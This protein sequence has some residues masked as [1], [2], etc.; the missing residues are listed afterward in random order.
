MTMHHRILW[1][2]FNPHPFAHPRGPAP[3]PFIDQTR[4]MTVLSRPYSKSGVVDTDVFASFTEHTHNSRL[5]LLNGVKV[6]G[7]WYIDSMNALRSGYGPSVMMDDIGRPYGLLLSASNTECV[8]VILSR[9]AFKWI[10][11]LA[12]RRKKPPWAVTASSGAVDA[13]LPHSTVST[14]LS[15]FLVLTICPFTFKLPTFDNL[16]P[17]DMSELAETHGSD[18]VEWAQLMLDYGAQ[19]ENAIALYNHLETSGQLV[20][21]LGARANDLSPHTNKHGPCLS[22]VLCTSSSHPDDYWTLLSCLGG[23]A[24]AAAIPPPAPA[25][26]QFII[27]SNEETK[28]KNTMAAVLGCEK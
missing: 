5:L 2:L 28:E 3:F 26:Q 11:V 24:T 16:G 12:P 6:C 10:P 21:H 17:E 9:S 20:R 8:G 15:L 13:A 1:P 23:A 25:P 14:N 7:V 22:A 19:G 18:V 27:T 4:T